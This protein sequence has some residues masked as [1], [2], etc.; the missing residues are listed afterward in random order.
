MV[1]IPQAVST[2]AIEYNICTWYRYSR[3]VS[4]PQAVG[5]IAILMAVN[6]MPL[7]MKCFNT[8]SG[9]CYC[10]VQT[11]YILTDLYRFNTASGKCY[12]NLEVPEGVELQAGD[13]GFNTASGKCYCN[14]LTTIVE[15]RTCSFQ[16][17][18]R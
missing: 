5:D 18:K 8:A 13:V 14:S 12:C 17:R 15:T 4:I 9:K 7:M 3:G 11:L 2:I 1:L 16:Y 10:N 6:Y